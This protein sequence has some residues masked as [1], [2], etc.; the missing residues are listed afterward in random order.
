MSVVFSKDFH[1]DLEVDGSLKS[2][3][4]DFV[5]KLST[6]PDLTGLDFKKPQG[7]L[8]KRVRT[9]RV[10]LNYRAVLFDMSTDGQS[11]Y[12]LAA[13][14]PHDDAYTLAATLELRVNPVNG[15]AEVLRHQDV[16]D[17]MHKQTQDHPQSATSDELRRVLPY[18]VAELTGIG[19]IDEA[20]RRAVEL[21][22]DDALQELCLAV[23]EWQGDVLLQLAYGGSLDEIRELY[24]PAD[25]ATVASDDLG[26]AF[27][28]PAARM[29]FVVVTDENDDEL[30]AM[31]EGDFRA[32]RTFLH[33]DQRAV[34]YRERWNGAFRLSGGAGTGK[35]VVAIHRAA[36]L[37]RQGRPRVLLTTFTK[38]LAAQL[39]ADLAQL[40]GPGRVS[41]TSS[42]P[43]PGTVRV[44]GV[45]SIARAIVAKADG[46]VP[47]VIT[48]QEADRRWEEAARDLPDLTPQEA[49]LLTVGF[50]R[51]EYGN[52]VLA[53]EITDKQG[54]LKAPRKGRGV[55]LNWLQRTRVWAAMELFTRRLEIDGATTFTALV[56]R[57]ARI[58][59]DPEAR[60]R[61]D[62]FDHVIVDEGQDLHA[63]HWLMLR[64]LVS[65]APNDLFICEDSHQRIYGERLTLSHFGI[66]VRGRSRK[67]T[68]NYRTTRQNLRFALQI[69]NGGQVV[70]LEGENENQAGYRSRLSGL[71]P[72]LR[73]AASAAAE[74]RLAVET[75]NGWLGEP[76]STRPAPDSIGVLVRTNRQRDDLAR[77]L[78]QAGLDVET[79][80]GDSEA[81]HKGVQVATMHR[82]KGMEFARVLVADVSD[83]VLP[84]QWLLDATAE[85]DRGDVEQR[86][87]LLL[88][89]ACTRAR[90]QLVVTWH[91][92]P[93]RYLPA[94]SAESL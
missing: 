42:A 51:A 6:D 34:A 46:H 1:K 65:R 50:L 7:A 11:F 48:D 55:R 81:T 63:T 33:P 68:L 76:A 91:G 35:T 78:R 22:D 9:A 70:D 56:A 24:G 14:K 4:W 15:I 94:R 26:K 27:E 13:I 23:P 38:T 20:A 57:A 37:S 87:R 39:E 40:A 8:D 45:D 83:D 21:T 54:Y 64:R 2:K 19:L 53:Q 58:L 52:V 25:D 10:D 66:D 71:E 31:L 30:R 86:E 67:L 12:L 36:F 16:R 80:A 88:Y 29:Q 84:S 28:H 41:R 49:N 62:T 77:T 59:A 44:S 73:G 60:S 17:V 69:L 3:A 47:K 90:D 72:V 89:V 18:T 85:E 61:V 79:L 5:R 93:S 32:W 75:I 43:E 74:H 82:A 92:V